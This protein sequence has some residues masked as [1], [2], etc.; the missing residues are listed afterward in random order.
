[1]KKKDFDQIKNKSREDLEKVV[2][3]KRAELTETN[4][5]SGV[6]GEKNKKKAKTLRRE[7][8]QILTLIKEKEIVEK[9]SKVQKERGAK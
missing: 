3:E 4:T 6:S 7:I 9:I 1:M 5:L 2:S 8:A